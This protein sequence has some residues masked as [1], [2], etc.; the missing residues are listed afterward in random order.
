MGKFLRF[1]GILFM[2]LSSALIL[3]SGV[4]T[5]CVALDATQYEGMEAI[6]QFQWLYILYVLAF[7]AFGIMGI[8]ATIALVRGKENAYRDSIIV[9]VL[10]LV[11]GAIHMATS[12]ALREGGSSMPLDFIVYAVVFTL[13]LFIILGIPKVKQMVGFEEGGSNGKTAA[14][15]MTAIVMGMLFLSVH[16]W[17]GPTHIFDG[18]NLADA[19]HT[20]MMVGGG[21]L[22]IIGLGMF[23]YAVLNSAKVNEVIPQKSSASA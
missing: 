12:Q 3:L 13:I 21:I 15:G 5:T 20:Q 6:A 4:G 14:G 18:A 11:V 22:F 8:R 9:L 16:M 23:V 1:I 10:S 19:F 17:A 2:G 7:V